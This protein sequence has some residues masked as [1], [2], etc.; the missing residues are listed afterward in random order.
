MAEDDHEPCLLAHP[1][2]PRDG[3]GVGLIGEYWRFLQADPRSSGPESTED[4]GAVSP[5]PGFFQDPRSFD[6]LREVIFPELAARRRSAGWRVCNLWSVGCGSGEEAYSLA[7]V[8]EDALGTL[9]PAWPWRI[10][11]SEPATRLLQRA[12]I[13]VYPEEALR[14]VPT[15]LRTAGFERGFGPQSGRIRVRSRLQQNI[16]FRDLAPEDGELPFREPFHVIVC[17]SAFSRWSSDTRVRALTRLVS[18]LLPGGY[19][20]TGPSDPLD[21]TLAP[22][23]RVAPSVYRRLL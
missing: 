6:F 12:R 16:T 22:L 10:E 18:N 1:S 14:D 11:A 8:T 13:G 15:S 5:E 20:I 3:S 2:A 9:Q 4:S 7:L 17:R 19:L 23:S 21:R